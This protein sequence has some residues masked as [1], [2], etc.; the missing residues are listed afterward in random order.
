[1][2]K[3]IDHEKRKVEILKTALQVIASEGY[4]DSNLSLIAEKCGISRPTIY[5]YFT[6]KDEI[7]Y[8]AVKLVTGNMFTRYAA[9]IWDTS[10]GDTIARI[11]YICRDIVDQ[12]KLC[13]GELRAL[14][15]VMLQRKKENID[16]SDIIMK[17]TAKL[18]ILFK[19]LLSH[20][21]KIGEVK[22][23]TDI[24]MVS[25]HIFTLL[26]AFCFQIAFLGNFNLDE[27]KQFVSTYL[28]FFRNR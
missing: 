5:Q 1:M 28:E 11:T 9:I 12:A 19:R 3:K 7:C 23:G 20:G 25:S 6:D 22:E 10:Y 27:A 8:Y 24:N 14:M 18:T 2:P 17:R 15:D 4:R 21:M 26:E 16:F 13:E